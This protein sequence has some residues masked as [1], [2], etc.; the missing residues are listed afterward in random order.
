MT[1]PA[2]APVPASAM[3]WSC[4]A[5]IDEQDNYCRRCGQGRGSCL[6]WYY[7][8]WGIILMTILGLGPF[9]LVLVYKAPLSK[10]ER[11]FLGTFIIGFSLFLCMGMV[12]L[13]HQLMTAVATLQTG[14]LQGGVGF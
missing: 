4:Q 11:M 2:P 1:T 3:C 6:V 5:V 8:W 13:A 12:Q 14:L 9:G 10:M 7:T